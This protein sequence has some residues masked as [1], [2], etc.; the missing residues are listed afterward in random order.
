MS[1]YNVNNELVLTTP[2]QNLTTTAKTQI[3]IGMPASLPKRFRIYE[4]EMSASGVPNATDCPIVGD[5]LWVTGATLGTVGNT[6]TPQANDSGTAI[7]TAIDASKALAYTNFTAEPT[8]FNFNNS[9]WYRAF[10]QRSGVLYQSVPGKE[11]VL[12]AAA[13]GTT[14][15]TGGAL[16]A[17]S[18]NYASTVAARLSY[19]DL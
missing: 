13:Q 9:W 7:G 8:V 1:G 5:L 16:R 11:I 2:P 3:V 19:E 12:P 6:V 10:N 17:L 15:T 14:A 18:P 4:I